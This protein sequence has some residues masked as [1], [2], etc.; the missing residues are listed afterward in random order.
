MTAS[1]GRPSRSPSV[2]RPPGS[3]WANSVDSDGSS[4]IYRTDNARVPAASLSDGVN[5]AGWIA[6]S[7]PT[8][9]TPGYSSY[10]FCEGQCFYDMWLASPPGKPDEVYYGGSMQYSEIFVA[11]RPSNGRAVMRSVNAGVSFTDMTR[12]SRKV[13]GGMHPDQHAVVFNPLLP[14]Q[15]LAASDGGLALTSGA[16]ADASGECASRNLTGADLT[17]CQIWLKGIPTKVTPANQGLRTLEF[18]D[19]EFNPANPTSIVLGG[20]QDNGTWTGK[21]G[22]PALIESVG[23]DGGLSGYDAAR[24]TTTFH[25][26]YGPS[27]DVNFN[28]NAT[29]GWNYVSD[30]LAKSGE[31]TEFYMAAIT[32]PVVGGTQFAGMQHVWRT[33]DNGG[34]RTYLQQ[35][36]NEYTGDFAATCGDWVALGSDLTSSSFG[37]DHR[38]WRDRDPQ[39]LVR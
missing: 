1:T 23:G 33:L 24:S 9:G 12:D 31:A 29:L 13:P 18:Q 21:A 38:R 2:H 36:C 3:I 35:H 4:A 6:L 15:I 17:D 5:D 32:D 25:T 8:P 28:S 26:Y 30:P 11:N 27:M 10:H 20:T 16:F 7:S 37:S 19:M 22:N 39:A 14:E 34:P